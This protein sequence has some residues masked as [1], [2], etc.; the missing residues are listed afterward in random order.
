[1]RLNFLSVAFLLKWLVAAAFCFAPAAVFAQPKYPDKPIQLIVPYAVG[2]ASDITFRLLAEHMSN[3]L[4]RRV[5]AE[6]VTGASGLIGLEKGRRAAPD[7]YTLVGTSDTV[8]IYLPL[9][10]KAATFNPVTDFE[11]ISVLAE[12]EWVLVT[13]PSFSPKTL[14]ELIAH[15]K[16]NPG[17]VAYSSGGHG[18]PQHVAMEYLNSRAGLEMIH[19]PYKGL[20]PAVLG[21]V[22]GDVQM[23]W[24]SVAGAGPLIR[25]GRLR[26]IAMATAK[27]SEILPQVPTAS[28]A[29]LPGFEFASWISLSGPPGMSPEH[30]RVLQEATAKAF[31]DPGIRAKLFAAGLNPVAS[32]P[33]DFRK[34]LA[35]DNTKL[36]GLVRS[37]NI[38]PE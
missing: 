9:L 26:A 7:G 12:V 24:A 29:G 2:S 33:G 17:K 8:L 31:A 15:V 16:A 28:E 14:T 10:L 13:P 20:T 37:I 6:N 5:V 3:Q 35:A 30:V 27:R 4:G 18:S 11:P 25:E 19:V 36:T 32:T 22:S 23:L 1:M 34:R 21:V 38:K